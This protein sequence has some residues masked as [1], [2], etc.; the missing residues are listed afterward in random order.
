MKRLL[1]DT[2]IYGLI[3]KDEDRLEIVGK[4]KIS[5]KIIIYGFK[6]IRNELRDTPKLIKIQE[7]SLRIDL[8]NLYDDIVEDH[9][10]EFTSN[11]TKIAEDYYK[12][13][14]EFGGTKS[15]ETI[16]DDFTIV[17]AGSL[18][19]LDIIVSNDE[20]SMLTENAIRAY[21]LINSVIN[22]RTPRFISY[23]QFKKV[24]RGGMSNELF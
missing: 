16:I 21:N 19:E 20:K 2:N 7:R 9:I 10:I 5:G 24:L 11:I 6:I 4:I 15:K 12:A 22:K 8:L 17:S 18:N 13:Y 14:R 23:N 1:V 3:A